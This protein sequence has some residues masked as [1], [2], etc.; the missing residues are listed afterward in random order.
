MNVTVTLE[1]DQMLKISMNLVPQVVAS[2]V[3]FSLFKGICNKLKLTIQYLTK[4]CVRLSYF[5]L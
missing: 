1:E 4:F 2:I 3:M 5:L